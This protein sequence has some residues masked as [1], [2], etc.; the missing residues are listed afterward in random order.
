MYGSIWSKQNTVNIS[1]VD[2]VGKTTQ[3]FYMRYATDLDRA[4][5]G[6]YQ[7]L[8]QA[9]SASPLIAALI[10]W[11]YPDLERSSKIQRQGNVNEVK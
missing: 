11:L 6:T 2:E 7:S 8:D 5:T 1:L 9:D 10:P 4:W 3:N